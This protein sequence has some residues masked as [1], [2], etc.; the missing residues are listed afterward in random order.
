VSYFALAAR[1]TRGRTTGLPCKL[2]PVEVELDLFRRR[3]FFI[4]QTPKFSDFLGPAPHA[5]QEHLDH[6][7]HVRIGHDHVDRRGTCGVVECETP[8]DA[9]ATDGFERAQLAHDILRDNL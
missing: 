9:V 4:W 2:R 5:P 8:C 1:P 6:I 3:P 7:E